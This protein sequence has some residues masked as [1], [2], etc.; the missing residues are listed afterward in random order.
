MTPL[1]AS[2]S[3]HTAG[4]LISA[5]GRTRWLHQGEQQQDGLDVDAASAKAS[6]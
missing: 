4:L 2:I 1:R 3:G 5:A 6:L